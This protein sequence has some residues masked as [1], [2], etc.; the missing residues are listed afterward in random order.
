MACSRFPARIGVAC[1][2]LAEARGTAAYSRASSREIMNL[3]PRLVI[4][5]LTTILFAGV[6]AWSARSYGRTVGFAFGVNWILIAWAILLGRVMEFPRGRRNGLSIRLP[7]WYYVTRSFEKGG[8]LYDYLGIRWYRRLLGPWLWAVKPALL[9]SEPGARQTMLRAT[10]DPEAG[11]SIIFVVI[12]GITIWALV[13]GWWDAAAWLLL[14]NLLHNAYPVM[15]MRQIRARL[16]RAG[17]H[18]RRTVPG[19]VSRHKGQPPAAE[20]ERSR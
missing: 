5:T 1:G 19:N 17:N 15:S 7:E 3:P 2:R 10:R 14:F 12:I 11:H 20:P 9:R 6:V 18:L 13:C 16:D 8:R 4:G